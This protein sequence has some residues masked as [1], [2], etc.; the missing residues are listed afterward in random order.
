MY[1]LILKDN[2]GGEAQFPLVGKLVVGRDKN[3]DII[4][5]DKKISRRHASFKLKELNLAV[6]KD[7]GSSNGTYVNGIKIKGEKEIRAGDSISIGTNKLRIMETNPL[8][9]FAHTTQV[10]SKELDQ[11]DE[12]NGDNSIPIKNSSKESEPLRQKRVSVPVKNSK[13]SQKVILLLVAL[14]AGSVILYFLLS[15]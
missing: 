10:G 11:F 6:V 7:L 2:E 1:K 15:K 3:C 13:I 14:A 5:N 9:D 4:I 12:N 8:K